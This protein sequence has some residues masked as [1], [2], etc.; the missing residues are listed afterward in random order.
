MKR[1]SMNGLL[2]PL[3]LSTLKM[4]LVYHCLLATVKSRYFCSGFVLK[5]NNNFNSVPGSAN[6]KYWI[7]TKLQNNLTC[8]ENVPEY[9]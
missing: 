9:K 6:N 8:L 2:V 1:N 5:I 7:F 4:M 3:S